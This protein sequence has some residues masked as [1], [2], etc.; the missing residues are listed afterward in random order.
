MEARRRI[1]IGQANCMQPRVSLK[2]QDKNQTVKSEQI[3]ARRRLDL[4]GLCNMTLRTT[5]TTLSCA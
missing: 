3:K 4:S 2:V 5:L 1:Q